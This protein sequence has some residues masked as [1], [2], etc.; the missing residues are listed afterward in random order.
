MQQLYQQL[1]DEVEEGERHGGDPNKIKGI[2]NKIVDLQ[3]QVY[4]FE[5]REQQCLEAEKDL[6]W[7]LEELKGIQEFKPDKERIEFRP[8]F[9]ARLSIKGLCVLTAE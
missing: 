5:D 9:L 4:D 2:T 6:E 3:N 1:Y 8:I 7:L